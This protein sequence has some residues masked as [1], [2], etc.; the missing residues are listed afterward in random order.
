MK[1]FLPVIKYLLLIKMVEFDDK[2]FHE[3]KSIQFGLFNPK[4]LTKLSVVEV[5]NLQ[6]Y[7]ELMQPKDNGI[8]D[9]KMGTT[10]KGMTCAS[11]NQKRDKCPGHFGHIVLEKPCLNPLMMAFYVKLLRNI[12]T[13]CSSLL[14]YNDN[15]DLSG[16]HRGWC[17]KCGSQQ[18]RIVRNGMVIMAGF[19]RSDSRFSEKNQILMPDQIYNIFAKVSDVDAA[20]L[21]L[22]PIHSRPEWSVLTVLP[23]SPPSI[24]PT[25]NFGGMASYD[26]VS[27]SLL[28]ILKANVILKE[29]MNANEG[30]YD[31]HMLLQY[32]VYTMIDNTDEHVD[33]ALLHGKGKH[34]K[35]LSERIGK[36]EGRIRTNLMGKRTSFTGRTVAGGDPY[37]GVDE[38]GVPLKMAL[39]LTIPVV[40]TKENMAKMRVLIERG[41]FSYPGA[42][43]IR[44]RTLT[45]ENIRETDENEILIDKIIDLSRTHSPLD[46]RLEIG[47]IVDRHMQNG[48]IVLMNRQPS[49]HKM[50]IMGF[51]AQ[52]MP[53]DTLRVNVNCTE[54]F[55]LDFD[56]K[57]T[58]TSLPSTGK[59]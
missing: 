36:K 43:F 19:D 58:L 32:R 3:V 45:P 7:D 15:N 16:H 28:E 42:K 51:R 26:E 5:N 57:A 52:I 41:P 12:C 9:L 14:E 20:K 21:K 46:L 10:E 33:Q 6:P 37:I 53:F 17:P 50:S 29:K 1:H 47:D 54:P 56:G 48:D 59:C 22:N 23:C 11:C 30:I 4:E 49:L 18:P 40:V 38:L 27:V 55:N 39:N 25:I 2:L 24:R 44:R 35:S 13:Y 8:F 31:A 34:M